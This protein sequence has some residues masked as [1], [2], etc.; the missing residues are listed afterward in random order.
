MLTSLVRDCEPA[1]ETLGVDAF[2]T[3]LLV[4]VGA[5]LGT[6]VTGASLLD[7]CPPRR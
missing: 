1:A 7:E 2:R 6:A 5:A 3:K 4:D